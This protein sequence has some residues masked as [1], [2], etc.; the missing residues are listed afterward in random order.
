VTNAKNWF[1]DKAR[2]FIVVQGRFAE[3]GDMVSQ[4]PVGIVQ[5]GITQ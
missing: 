2:F 5:I 1:G 4:H 3:G